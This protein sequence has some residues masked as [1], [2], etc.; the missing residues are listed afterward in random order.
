MEISHLHI[1]L[2]LFFAIFVGL[3]LSLPRNSKIPEIYLRFVILS[4]SSAIV[5]TPFVWLL[6][7]AFKSNEAL[8]QFLFLPSPTEISNQTINL[9]NF[10]RLFSDARETV[11]GKVYFIEYIFNSI[12]L[13][14]ATTIAQLLFCSMGGYALAKLEFRGKR[15]L[16]FFM[17]GTMMLPTM[18]LLAPMYEMMVRIGWIDTY[19]ALIVP[20]AANAFGMFLFRQA[21]TGVPNDLIEAGRLDGCTEFSIYWNLVMPLVRPMSGAFCLICF[22]ASWNNFLGPQIFIQSTE[23]LTLPVVLSQ[24]VGVYSV[25]YGVFLAGTLIAIIPPAILF[26]ALQKEFIVG[27]TSGAVK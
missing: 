20:G 10:V 4:G 22:L 18:I 23:K 12:F 5:L 21:I 2:L 25:Q 13:A 8:F 11:H 3:K 24:Y 6:C 7:A 14:T 17:L 9:G 26:F 16:M 27:L 19:W 15:L 1:T